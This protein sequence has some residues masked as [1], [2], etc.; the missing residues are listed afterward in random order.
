M[1]S[2]GIVIRLR[3]VPIHFP[4]SLRTRKFKP[5]VNED[6]EIES[7]N[8]APRVTETPTPIQRKRVANG[9]QVD[10]TL[11]VRVASQNS[12]VL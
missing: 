11:T 6:N 10:P 2:F 1:I 4:R 7:R 12:R 9:E 3:N 8:E 5:A